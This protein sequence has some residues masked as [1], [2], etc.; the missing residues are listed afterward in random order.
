MV[1]GMQIGRQLKLFRSKHKLSQ[2]EFAKHISSSQQCVS[3]Y[4][5]GITEPSIELLLR[6]AKV[7]HCTIDDVLGLEVNEIEHEVLNL[8]GSMS[9]EQRSLS[10][11][12][13]KTIHDNSLKGKTAD[14]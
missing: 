8:L 7:F 10:I 4:E 1:R 2:R 11:Q 9:D 5:R 3:S 6:I 14:E 12:I 13:L